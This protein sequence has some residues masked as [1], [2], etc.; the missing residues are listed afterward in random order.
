MSE[1]IKK[2]KIIRDKYMEG[3]GC[4]VRYHCQ[5]MYTPTDPGDNEATKVTD[6]MWCGR[7][8]RRT[9]LCGK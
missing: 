5:H 7:E 8:F 9:A 1:E 2:A 3:C 4:C 6:V